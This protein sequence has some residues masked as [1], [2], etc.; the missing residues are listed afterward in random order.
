MNT[1]DKHNRKFVLGF[2]LGFLAIGIFNIAHHVMWRDEL[3]AWTIARDTPTLVEL[4]TNIRYEG[5]P[6]L[7]FLTLYALSGITPNPAIMQFFHLVLATGAVYMVLRY[8]PFSKLQKVLF[9]F[10]YYPFYEYCVISRDYSSGLLLLLIFL[11]LLRP[12]IEDKNYISLSIVLFFLCQSNPYGAVIAIALAL[13]LI[14]EF[15]FLRGRASTISPKLKWEL[16]AGIFIFVCGLSA[17]AIQMRPPQD[18]CLYHPIGDIRLVL[19]NIFEPIANIW[20]GYIPIPEFTMQFWGSNFITWLFTDPVREATSRFLLSMAIV[21]LS[22][23]CFLRHPAALFYYAVGT[24]GI[25]LFNNMIYAGA[26]R[27]IGHYFIVFISALWISNL[28]ENKSSK[29]GIVNQKYEYIENNRNAFFTFILVLNVIASVTANT[30]DYL[31]PFSANKETAA[32]IKNNGLDQM[33]ILGDPDFIAEG[34]A[35]YLN[36]PIYYP[37]TQRYATFV[38]WDNKR[39]RYYPW[40][41][42]KA[43]EQYSS[44]QKRDILLVLNYPIAPASLAAYGNIYLVKAFPG[45]A[46]IDE[47]FCLYIMKYVPH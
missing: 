23:I 34:V 42:L 28:Y 40:T 10:G 1:G 29:S 41:I 39:Q 15:I 32:Y 9:M 27:H 22:S 24:I 7:W 47:K 18:S 17:S 20:N 11:S 25:I 13:M 3:H 33:P 12:K 37:A 31:Y 26:V 30:L 4:F 16:M 19:I 2:A 45:S 6:Y 38:I 14:F 35:D 46:L 8:A 5:H 21:T 44:S 43:A 36:R